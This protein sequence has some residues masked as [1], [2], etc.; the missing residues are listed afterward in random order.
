M[1]R[2]WFRFLR[3][4]VLVLLVLVLIFLLLLL[5]IC[6]V[7]MRLGM[8]CSGWFLVGVLSKENTRVMRFYVYNIILFTVCWFYVR[9]LI[10]SFGLW[11][12]FILWRFIVRISG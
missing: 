6:S 7:L 3:F 1:S 8:K 4:G 2:M 5:R 10:I 12:L 11:S 9:G